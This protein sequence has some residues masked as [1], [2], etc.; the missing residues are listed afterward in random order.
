MNSEYISKIF[1]RTSLLIFLFYFIYIYIYP[2]SMV[3]DGFVHGA[4][5]DQ[6]AIVILVHMC[7]GHMT[8]KKIKSSS[9]ESCRGWGAFALSGLTMTLQSGTR[10]FV[11][12][13]SG[14]QYHIRTSLFAAFIACCLA[15]F[16][17]RGGGGKH[18][19]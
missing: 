6:A 11:V 12:S 7:Q 5:A 16:K 10:V 9:K 2:C 19:I 1:F 8:I 3:N 15:L 13:Q 17:W 4:H 18:A 14:L